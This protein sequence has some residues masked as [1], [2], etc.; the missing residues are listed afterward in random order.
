MGTTHDRVAR[1]LRFLASGGMADED[2]DMTLVRL[3]VTEQVQ[4]TNG[5]Y[6]LGAPAEP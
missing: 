2:P 6:M 1:V 5:K 3:A 4:E